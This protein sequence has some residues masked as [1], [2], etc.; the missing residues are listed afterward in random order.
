MLGFIG[1]VSD[2]VYS[3]DGIYWSSEAVTKFK[4]KS[5]KM[6]FI[7]TVTKLRGG[8][9]VYSKSPKMGFIGAVDKVYKSHQR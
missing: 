8:D 3:K 2:K 4:Q 9:K 1:A 7:G 5:P 6:G